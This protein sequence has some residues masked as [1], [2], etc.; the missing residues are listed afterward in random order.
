MSAQW[1]ERLLQAPNPPDRSYEDTVAR[2]EDWPSRSESVVKETMEVGREAEG[3]KS[4]KENK[5]G[6]QTNLIKI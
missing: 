6:K 5:E 1:R 4:R 3:T 2:T